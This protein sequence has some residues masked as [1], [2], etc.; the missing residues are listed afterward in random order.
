MTKSEIILG[1]KPLEN[2]YYIEREISMKN[3]N[4]KAQINRNLRKKKIVVSPSLSY[5]HGSASP[6]I[7]NLYRQLLIL[8]EF[9]LNPGE[10]IILSSENNTIDKKI[11][12]KRSIQKDI[13]CDNFSFRE[14]LFEKP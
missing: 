2:R 4:I 3:I 14:V 8:Q 7:S 10:Y 5:L 11:I 6:V 13:T 9:S 1:F 12:H